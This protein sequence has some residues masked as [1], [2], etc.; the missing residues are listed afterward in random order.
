MPYGTVKTYKKRYG[1]K[2][3]SGSVGKTPKPFSRPADVTPVAVI[4]PKYR[5]RATVPTSPRAYSQPIGAAPTRRKPSGPSPA[6]VAAKKYHAA[7]RQRQREETQRQRRVQRIINKDYPGLDAHQEDVLE[8]VLGQG[9]KQGVSRQALKSAIETGLVESN[10]RN[11]GFG[12]ADSLGWRQE[13][14]SIYG[15]GRKGATNVRA[16]ARRYFKE[17]KAAGTRST[18]GELAQA[19]QSSAHPERYDQFRR[20][21]R[22]ILKTYTNKVRAL[23][24][25]PPKPDKAKPVKG[26]LSG[27]WAG[28]KKSVL[29]HIPKGARAE[30][31]DDKRTPAENTAVGG[32]ANSDHLTTKTNAYGA[33]IDPD[34]RTYHKIQKRLGLPQ[35]NSGSQT[36]TKDGYRYQL[37]FG[38]EYGH[39]DHIHLGAEWVGGGSSAPAPG[40]VPVVNSMGQPIAGGTTASGSVPGAGVTGGAT[41]AAGGRGQASMRTRKRTQAERR[42]KQLLEEVI[43]RTPERL[44]APRLRLTATREAARAR[45]Q[46]VRA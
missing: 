38:A 11:L 6:K 35:T 37:I 10:L 13:R 17:A 42:R 21:A 29:Q 27:A 14:T 28:A 39:E 8:T 45:E 3:P 34:L 30:G 41:A 20:P 33:D 1:K 18:A 19:V 2:P 22:K 15:A 31:R 24:G 7:R 36:V 43:A 12:D 32:A 9:V 46:R 4:K 44:A 40:G 16:S 26:R 5:G 23:G 25:T